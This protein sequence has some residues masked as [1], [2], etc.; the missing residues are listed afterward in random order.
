MPKSP[1]ARAASQESADCFLAPL[2]AL[3]FDDTIPLT[4]QAAGIYQAV[5]ARHTVL[6]IPFPPHP[7]QSSLADDVSFLG[8]V[9]LDTIFSLKV[10]HLSNRE[11]YAID[12]TN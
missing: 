1:Y 7:Q 6:S 3:P 4:S 8:R 11:S 9:A 10:F 12:H 2:L 5:V